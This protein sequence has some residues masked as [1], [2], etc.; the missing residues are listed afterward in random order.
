MDEYNA[1]LARLAQRD[2]RG[3]G[4]AGGARRDP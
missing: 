1:M 3:T 2:A 4:D